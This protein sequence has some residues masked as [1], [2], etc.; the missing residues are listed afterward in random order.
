MPIKVPRRIAFIVYVSALASGAMLTLFAKPAAACPTTE[1]A[2]GQSCYS[3]G[4]IIGGQTC[5]CVNSYGSTNCSW[6]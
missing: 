2:D 1:C 3:N 4:R 5:S 6:I